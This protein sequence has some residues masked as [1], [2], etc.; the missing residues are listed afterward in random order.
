M[1]EDWTKL[2]SLRRFNGENLYAWITQRVI[3]DRQYSSAT[4]EEDDD[5]DDGDDNVDNATAGGHHLHSLQRK[6]RKCDSL[7][8][9]HA[10]Y[11][12]ECDILGLTLHILH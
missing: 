12:V 9:K 6:R 7:H 5:D 3:R 2:A 11:Y 1:K 10:E 4:A 8:S